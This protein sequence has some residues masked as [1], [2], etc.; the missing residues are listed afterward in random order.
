VSFVGADDC[1]IAK[2]TGEALMKAL[3]GKGEVI[4]IE[5]VRGSKDAIAQ[6]PGVKL[7]A[8]QPGN[9]RRLQAN[10]VMENLLQANPKVA[11]V[12]AANDAMAIGAMDALS[13][14]NSKALVVGI[15]GAKEAV[16]AI[17]AGKM[18]TSGDRRCKFREFARGRGARPAFPR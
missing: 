3:G 2:E 14:A 4:I 6:Y 7:V 12:L 9:H 1:T 17:K 8:S 16:D 15:N 18:L 11:G 13:D 5:G 10:Q